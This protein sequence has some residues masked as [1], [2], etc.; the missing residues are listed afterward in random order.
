[1]VLFIIFCG[2]MTTAVVAEE[3]IVATIYFSASTTCGTCVHRNETLAALEQNY[4]DR[5]VFTR[6]NYDLPE[7]KEEATQLG[8]NSHPGMI[9][10]YQS[11]DTIIQPTD[12]P[13]STSDE[14]YQ[15]LCTIIE[16]YIAAYELNNPNPANSFN[17][18][19]LEYVI[20]PSGIAVLVLLALVGFFVWKKDHQ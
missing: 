4:S 14:K 19:P 3:K 12:V 18:I 15:A 11:N 16:N 1:M 10:I 9:I 13:T 7:N 2:C 17:D 5:V 6:K 20:I 8:I